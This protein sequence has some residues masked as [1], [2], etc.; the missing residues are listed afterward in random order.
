[1]SREADLLDLLRIDP[2]SKA[3][4]SRENSRL[5][6]KATFNLGSAA[7]YLKTMAAFSN[8]RGGYLVF[9]VT[10]SPRV[11]TGLNRAKFEG[12]DPVRLTALLNSNLNPEVAWESGVITVHGVD[13]G[14]IY[15]H[16]AP[17]K[18]IIASSNLGDGLKEG[19]IYYR[20]RGQ[21]RTIAFPELRQIIDDRL[22][23]EREAWRRHFERIASIGPTN[24]GILDSVGGLIHGRGGSYLVDP[25]LLDRLSFIREG[26]FDEVDGAPALKVIGSVQPAGEVQPAV[27]VPMA[28]H[29]DEIVNSFL[30]ERGM[31][32]NE[33]RAFL[34]Q[35][36]RQDSYYQPLHF[37]RRKAGMSVEEAQGLL[38]EVH[39]PEGRKRKFAARLDGTERVSPLAAVTDPLPPCCERG[40][41]GAAVESSGGSAMDVRSL[42]T[43]ALSEDPVVVLDGLDEVEPRRVLEAMTCVAPQEVRRH[44]HVFRSI[45]S[46]YFLDQFYEWPSTDRT[47]FRKAM[48]HL[49][50]VLYDGP[51]EFEK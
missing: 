4:S 22:E 24:V 45:L 39:I 40:D 11:A 21:S 3:V 23:Q 30:G 9:G 37:L 13:L 32:P 48:T 46:N 8:A 18:P 49:D 10:D 51:D 14:F 35:A 33:G 28:I 6:F 42:I 47:Y 12:V 31:T 16:E 20:Y 44:E 29:F 50:E 7:K 36:F 19:E 43:R 38:D 25:A 2:A 34:E 26:S 41:L 17:R 27:A 1:M 15:A 5:E